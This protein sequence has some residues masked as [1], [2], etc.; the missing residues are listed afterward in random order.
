MRLG[1]AAAAS[2][3]LATLLGGLTLRSPQQA[4]TGPGVMFDTSESIPYFIQDGAGVPGY[5]PSDR[6]LAVWALAAWSRESLGKLKFSEAVN[7]KSALIR[8]K[9]ISPNEGLFGETQHVVVGN[10]L[11]ALVYVMPQVAQLGTVAERAQTDSLMRDTI[12]Y[13]TCVHELGHAVGLPHTRNFEDIMYSFA[14]GGDIV[15]YFMRYRGRLKTRND[16][17]G[18]SGLSAGDETA[19][20]SLY[21]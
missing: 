6:E 19:L 11:G 20:R 3:A 17:T 7:E 15:A 4:G 18:F 13:L 8:L 2:I 21:Q 9:W 14:F 12:V 1:A 10:K 16:I 5:L